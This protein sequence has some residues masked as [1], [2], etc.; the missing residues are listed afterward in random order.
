M[1]LLLARLDSVLANSG[2]YVLEKEERIEELQGKRASAL[3]L[4][5]KLWINKMLY[6]EYFVYNADSAMA[7]VDDNIEIAGLLGRKDKKQEWIL[8]KVFLLTAQGLLHEA[9]KELQHVDMA[10]LGEETIFQ[11]Y[12]TKIYLYSHLVQFIGSR[13]ELVNSYHT[14]ETELKHEAKHHITPE[15]P[16]YYSFCASLHKE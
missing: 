14:L 10:S 7:Y 11:Y 2:K 6:D 3:K 1:S 15:H 5:D 16:S 4:E 13:L 9:E 12:D 8:N